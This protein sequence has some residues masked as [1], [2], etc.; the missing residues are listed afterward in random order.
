MGKTFAM[1]SYTR[2]LTGLLAGLVALTAMQNARAEPDVTPIAAL[3][4]RIELSY[5]QHDAAGMEAARRELLAS[6]GDRA[7]Y[8]AAYA[9]FRQGL[10]AEGDNA[11]AGAYIDDCII[12]LRDYVALHEDDAEARALLG[13]CYGI[14]TRY[15]RLGMASRGLEA[16]RQMAAARQL[17]PQNPWV[18]LQD[19]LADY[20]T[21]RLFGGDRKLAVAKLERAAELFAAAV[22]EGSRTAAWAAA[23]TWLQLGHM[24]TKAGHP[25]DASSAYA[26][27]QE[28]ARWSTGAPRQ[29]TA[30]L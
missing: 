27:A 12:E 25:E 6:D 8:Y 9:R 5:Q 18:M 17:A 1:E 14:S 15:H 10:A 3:R 24:Y 2:R 28:L 21:P 16:R 7:A 29:L 19:G 22:Q 26:R 11:T 30:N 23:E 13:S 20:A 4:E